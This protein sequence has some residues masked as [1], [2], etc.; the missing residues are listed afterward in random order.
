MRRTVSW[1]GGA[2]D[3]HFIDLP[4]EQSPR[5]WAKS[6]WPGPP[7]FT[8]MMFS[9]S[10]HRCHCGCR[11]ERAGK[12]PVNEQGQL[13]PEICL[14][15]VGCMVEDQFH[16]VRFARAEHKGMGSG[17][18]FQHRGEPSDRETDEQAGQMRERAPLRRLSGSFGEAGRKG[19]AKRLCQDF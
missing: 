4:I 5:L 3:R 14:P 12:L 9:L 15:A 6:E 2:F 16:P 7:R 10:C 11:F 13:G 19:H 1:P 8:R 18:G 17:Y